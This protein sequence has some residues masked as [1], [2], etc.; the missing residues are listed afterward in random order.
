MSLWQ[1][2]VFFSVMALVTALTRF[3]PFLLFPDGSKTPG[4]VRYLGRVLPYPVIGMLVVYCLKD[5]DIISRPHGLPEAAAI[6]VIA[7]IHTWKRNALLSIG[8]GTI[9]YMIMIQ[10]LA[11]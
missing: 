6:I 8:V 5:V 11:G 2:I 1:N 4:F 9:V 3:L 7:L 10:L